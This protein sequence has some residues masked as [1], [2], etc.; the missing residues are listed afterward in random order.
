MYAT[1]RQTNLSINSANVAVQ[2]THRISRSVSR[3]L[4]S[5]PSASKTLSRNTR[6][7]VTCGESA[8]SVS[9][10]K[11]SARR[12]AICALA[13]LVPGLLSAPYAALAGTKTGAAADKG[14][15][16][17]YPVCNAGGKEAR[18]KE[19]EEMMAMIAANKKKAA[20]APAPTAE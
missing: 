5:R 9:A 11:K 10:T 18:D 7:A 4:A 20:A 1:Y 19:Y 6:N 17:C 13:I 16:D 2:R 8:T 15:G 14:V 3:A 12:E